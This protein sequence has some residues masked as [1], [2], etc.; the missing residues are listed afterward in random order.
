[1]NSKI[2]LS[3]LAQRIAAA[4]ATSNEEALKF[5]KDLFAVIEAEV[6]V[7]EKVVIDGLGSFA[8][9]HSLTEPIIFTPD[10][11]FA[12]ELNEAF[13]LFSPTELNPEVTE[14]Q[15][16]A[17]AS[18]EPE[19]TAAEEREPEKIED[20]PDVVEPKEEVSV[21]ESDAPD[22][23]ESE[24]PEIPA[25]IKL[26]EAEP[27]TV[28]TVNETEASQIETI[29]ETEVIS[30]PETSIEVESQ[31]ADIQIEDISEA[32]NATDE[33]VETEEKVE[34]QENSADEAT[35]SQRCDDEETVIVKRRGS[36]LWTGII[37][38]FIL[39][40]ALGVIAFLAY[41]VAYL[42]IPVESFIVY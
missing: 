20:N 9:S 15:L 38:G 13:S 25:E 40:F 41:I 22:D 35:I 5:I 12:E 33:P 19:S 34:I 30:E 21:P 16:M 1:M 24:M 11:E 2:P 6:A 27:E 7:G 26:E 31:P 39:G 8:K 32:K 36:H 37:I 3:K 23:E 4:S 29:E 18:E 42:K 10:V 17:V 14:E 28:E